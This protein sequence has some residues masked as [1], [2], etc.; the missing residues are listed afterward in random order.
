MD[1]KEIIEGCLQG[2]RKYYGVLY[3]KYARTM[4]GLVYRYAKNK[5]DADDI[6]QEGF[7]KVFSNLSK[8]SFNGSFEGWIKRIMINQSLQY[9]KKKSAVMYVEDYYDSNMDTS[10]NETILSNFNYEQLLGFV[11]DLSDGC[12]LVFNM[13]AIEG[14][15]HKEIAEHLGISVGTSKSQLNYARKLLREKIEHEDRIESITKKATG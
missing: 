8:F 9:Y 4:Y 1:D 3:E 14:Y 15:S 12:R 7:S 10:S 5:S 11:N 6:L 2:K 13:Y